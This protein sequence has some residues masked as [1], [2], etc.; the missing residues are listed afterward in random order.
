MEAEQ[1]LDTEDTQELSFEQLSAA[2][3]DSLVRE[4]ESDDARARPQQIEESVSPAE[5]PAAQESGETEASADEGPQTFTVK[6]LA[7]T[8]NMDPAALYAG[9]QIDLGKGESMPLG[10][11]K[12]R[13]KDV[14][15]SDELLAE[16]QLNRSKVEAELLQKNQALVLAQQEAGVEVTE[17]HIK[18]AAQ[19]F[20]AYGE[21]QDRT[22]TELVPD[23]AQSAFRQEF[24][25][26]VD[27][28]LD[29]L[30]YSATEKGYMKDARLRLEFYQHQ[31]LLDELAAVT[32]KRVKTKRNQAPGSSTR[33]TS[34][35]E[36]IKTG[37]GNQDAKVAELGRLLG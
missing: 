33:V 34:S 9:L 1:N 5:S 17:Q 30:G 32:H 10:E 22:L 6:D 23:Y 13:L 36:A 15:R 14:A 11:F 21:L 19:Q 16:V 28:R 12:D 18:Q 8:L 4:R 35:V 7:E 27:K 26:K 25:S 31:R 20:K 24:D 29:A 2:L 3:N 37:K